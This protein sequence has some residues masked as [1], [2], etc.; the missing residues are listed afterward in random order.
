MRVSA[1]INKGQDNRVKL[2]EKQ[3]QQEQQPEKAP[4]VKK[5][6]ETKG[7]KKSLNLDLSDVP[8]SDDEKFS[9]DWGEWNNKF[10]QTSLYTPDDNITYMYIL[11]SD[12][13]NDIL[14]ANFRLIKG[15][16]EAFGVANLE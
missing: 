2:A 13:F 6:N 14:P 4:T 10:W 8:V 15:E 16:M 7:P 11:M 9:K 12:V 1:R 3:A 5:P